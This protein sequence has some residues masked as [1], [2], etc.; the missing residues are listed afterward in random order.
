MH[1]SGGFRPGDS[2]GTFFFFLITLEPRVLK[3]KVDHVDNS[4]D[5]QPF[6]TKVSTFAIHEK[7]T[8]SL[9]WFSFVE[10]MRVFFFFLITLEPSV[11]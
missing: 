3:V 4:Y 5:R 9:V 10:S 7:A 6:N 11:E 1:P 8:A 2:P